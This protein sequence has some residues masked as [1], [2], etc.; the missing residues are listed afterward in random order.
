MFVK[1]IFGQILTKVIYVKFLMSNIIKM[2]DIRWNHLLYKITINNFNILIFWLC[3]VETFLI[4]VNKWSSRKPTEKQVNFYTFFVST[5]SFK[6]RECRAK[7]QSFLSFS[8]YYG[9]W[10]TFLIFSWSFSI[11]RKKYSQVWHKNL[12]KYIYFVVEVKHPLCLLHKWKL[13]RKLLF[14]PTLI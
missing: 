10:F 8:W 4:L 5:R 14:T 1:A 11:H 3:D 7:I 13:Q 12:L 6:I 9:T 2:R